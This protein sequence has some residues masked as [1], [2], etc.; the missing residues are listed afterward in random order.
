MSG[1]PMAV[2]ASVFLGATTLTGTSRRRAIH[3]T[4]PIDERLVG[5]AALSRT[6]IERNGHLFRP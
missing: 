6:T 2:W 1:I 4:R 3:M 5:V